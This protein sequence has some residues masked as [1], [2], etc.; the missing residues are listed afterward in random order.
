MF[1]DA[2]KIV[3]VA[4]LVTVLFGLLIMAS[5]KSGAGSLFNWF[6]NLPLDIRIERENMRFY[7][8]I[9]S[10]LLLSLLL[11]IGLYVINKFIR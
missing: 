7:F 8:P 3:V 1:S 6:G 2:G 10:S 9:G 4:G 5:G 11:S